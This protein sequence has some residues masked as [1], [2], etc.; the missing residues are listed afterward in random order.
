MRSWGAMRRTAGHA[1]RRRAWLTGRQKRARSS[2]RSAKA[3]SPITSSELERAAP[4]QREEQVA[5]RPAQGDVA[6]G[7]GG[8]DLDAVGAERQ[9]PLGA[10]GRGRVV[11]AVDVH[12]VPGQLGRERADLLG[13]ADREEEAGPLVDAVGRAVGLERRRAPAR[14][15][16]GSRRAHRSGAPTPR[17]PGGASRTPPCRGRAKLRHGP[18][19]DRATRAGEQRVGGVAVGGQAVGA[20]GHAGRA[21]RRRPCPGR[22]RAASM[23]RHPLVDLA[24]VAHDPLDGPVLQRRHGASSEPAG[25]SARARSQVSAR[26]ISRWRCGS[27]AAVCPDPAGQRVERP[28][29]TGRTAPVM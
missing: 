14:R 22:A 4:P 2:R 9:Q 16:R 8:L 1:T 6:L 13:P 25:T 21:G 5:G 7:V 12:R 28:P 18:R 20:L 24:H 15:P 27:I 11:G 3:A 26:R 19:P 29:S 10:V 23:P 17:A